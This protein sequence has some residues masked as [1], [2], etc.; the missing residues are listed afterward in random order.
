MDNTLCLYGVYVYH[1]RQGS[2]YPLYWDFFL[3]LVS[4]RLFYLHDEGMENANSSLHPLLRWYLPFLA[5]VMF[6][7]GCNYIQV[8]WGSGL[9]F[10]EWGLGIATFS[11]A[12]AAILFTHFYQLQRTVRKLYVERRISKHETKDKTAIHLI[13]SHLF[14]SGRK[15][16]MLGSLGLSEEERALLIE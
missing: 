15:G 14:S 9:L 10:S 11:S 5:S 3:D 6:A 1:I 2:F 8:V 13:E 16:S 12:L 4:N 7:D